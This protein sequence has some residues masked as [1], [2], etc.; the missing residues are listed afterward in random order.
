MEEVQYFLCT[1]LSA[2]EEGLWVIIEN[3]LSEHKSKR[4]FLSDISVKIE[5]THVDKVHTELSQIRTLL[6]SF[7]PE[8]YN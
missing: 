3:A 7:Q 8:V 2:L 6:V 1:T 4:D 5:I